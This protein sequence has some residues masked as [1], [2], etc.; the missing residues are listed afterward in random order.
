MKMRFAILRAVAAVTAAS[1]L[2]GVIFFTVTECFF[3]QPGLAS[4]FGSFKRYQS[5]ENPWVSAW[6][7]ASSE[8]A[9]SPGAAAQRGLAAHSEWMGACG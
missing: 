4:A 3:G 6:P 9:N 5:G 2:A 8:A 1:L 7:G